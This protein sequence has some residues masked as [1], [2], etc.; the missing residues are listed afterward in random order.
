MSHLGD[1]P[2]LE[3]C[4]TTY[5][6]NTMSDDLDDDFEIVSITGLPAGKFRLGQVQIAP[7]TAYELDRAF[8]EQAL[9]RH[10]AGDWGEADRDIRISNER[11]L[12]GEHDFPI[13]S[14]YRVG[15]RLF[16]IATKADGS[17]TS[18]VLFESYHP[19]LPPGTWALLPA[20]EHVLA[21]L[22]LRHLDQVDDDDVEEAIAIADAAIA[23]AKKQR[24][25]E[26]ESGQ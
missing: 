4:L 1:M 16:Q 2:A 9:R 7:D 8:V 15:D 19:P 18:I 26:L 25:S 11:T 3:P 10:A 5:G 12:R 6:V 24:G 20:L 17:V 13:L 14:H 22:K 21:I 23:Q